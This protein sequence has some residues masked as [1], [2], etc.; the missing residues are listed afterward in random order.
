MTYALYLLPFV[1]LIFPFAAQA[2]TAARDQAIALDIGGF[3]RM[4]GSAVTQDDATGHIAPFDLLRDTEIY[5]RGKTVLQNGV[6]IGM[7]IETDVDADDNSSVNESYLYAL[8]DWGRINVGEEDGA[9]YLL[10]I[11]TPGADPNIDG[12]RTEIQPFNDTAA[13]LGGGLSGTYNLGY[14]NDEAKDA[15]K[16]TYLS[17]R[18]AGLQLGVSYAPETD[19]G[20]VA[21][22]EG[23]RLTNS[24][25]DDAYEAAMRYEGKLQDV[26]LTLGGGYTHI[27]NASAGADDFQEWNTGLDVNLAGFGMGAVYTEN[28]GAANNA[29]QTTW[30]IGV[31]Y[32]FDA[33]TL[34]GSYLHQRD[35]G[36][37]SQAERYTA[38]IHHDYAPG[39]RF[40]GV[41]MHTQVDADLDVQAT[42]TALLLGTQI[43]F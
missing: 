37:N 3:V 35:K 33:F 17:P 1:A 23:N 21:D 7:Q 16:I 5:F 12:A 39:V 43:D 41:A 40:S 8:G 9:A 36:D 22:V 6:T 28:N 25:L 42:G 29:D 4:Y 34:G 18:F 2:D 30:V 20:S 32:A 15:H 27:V 31:D 13:G 10:Q 14:G 24:G 19:D 38:G 26:K 11:T